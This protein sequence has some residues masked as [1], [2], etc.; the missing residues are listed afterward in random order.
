MMNFVR[1]FLSLLASFGIDIKRIILSLIN[2]PFFFFSFVKYFYD[3]VRRG[4]S[5][6]SFL[7][8]LRIY[9]ILHNRSSFSGV[10]GGHY[11]HQDLYVANLIYHEKP[12]LHLDIGSR[13]DGF[14]AHLLSFDQRLIV[15]DIRPLAIDSHEI[16]FLTIDLTSD[17]IKHCKS[18]DSI[19]CLHSIE[20]FGLGRY[21]DP[22]DPSGFSKG[23]FNLYH[24]LNVG[25]VLYLS[26]PITTASP[27]LLYFNAHRVINYESSLLVLQDVGFVIK[28][29]SF[30]DD[31][32]K[33]FK[34]HPLDFE[35]PRMNYGLGIY[36]LTR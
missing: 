22:I 16:D 30:V 1:Y 33:F 17:T 28:D 14:I 31:G 6:I 8:S 21:G 2:L 18:F 24:L 34:S 36:T 9:P 7:A 35:L 10:T 3:S 20:H 26:F 19:S 5:P 13:V 27:S 25:G 4:G 32:G 29:F 23:L 11:F 15:G 12:K